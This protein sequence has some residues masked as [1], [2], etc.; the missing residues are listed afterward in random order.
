MPEKVSGKPGQV[1]YSTR[2][3]ICS[4]IKLVCLFVICVAPGQGP[5]LS[6]SKG[7]T[8][9]VTPLLKLL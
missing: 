2:D 3:P 9:D 5:L 8:V 7:R 4:L 6:M 1:H